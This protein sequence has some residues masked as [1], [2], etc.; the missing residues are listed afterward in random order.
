MSSTYTFQKLYNGNYC[1][2]IFTAGK[3]GITE[4]DNVRNI[5]QDKM[6]ALD[7]AV[8]DALAAAGL[9]RDKLEDTIDCVIQSYMNDIT[10]TN[11]DDYEEIANK[12]CATPDERKTEGSAYMKMATHLTQE[13]NKDTLIIR[14]DGKGSN[15]AIGMINFRNFVDD[16]VNSY[17]DLL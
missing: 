14:R 1:I 2:E 13:V 16:I 7:N 4:P 8:I 3:R 10:N 12:G 5:A 17:S 9:D 11:V 15:Q 6:K